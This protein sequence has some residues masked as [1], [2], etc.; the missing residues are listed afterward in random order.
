MAR[1]PLTRLRLLAAVVVMASAACSSGEF[2]VIATDTDPRLL[3]MENGSPGE[4]AQAVGQL[5]YLDE[6]QCFVLE[7]QGIR[8]AAVWPE[9]TK[10][11]KMDNGVVG[12]DV[13]GVGDII[14][15][16]WLLGR[17]GYHSDGEPWNLPTVRAQ[18]LSSHGEY[19]F[20]EDI[21][22]SGTEPITP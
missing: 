16:T 22:R 7:F 15:G 13:P 1:P 21:T 12:V 8:Y 11:I 20:I 6:P 2:R 10:P 19:A 5:R 3:V 14:E 18:C 17:G 9:G 4:D